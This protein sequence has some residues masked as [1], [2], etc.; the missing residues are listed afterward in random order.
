MSDESADETDP[1]AIVDGF[2]NEL[3]EIADRLFSADDLPESAEDV[4]TVLDEIEDVLQYVDI[5]DLVAAIDLSKL[6]EAIDVSSVPE[7]AQSGKA[8]KAVHLR[9]LLDVVDLTDLAKSLDLRAAWRE[10]RELDDAVD[11]LM[12][13]D[14]LGGDGMFDGDSDRLGSDESHDADVEVEASGAFDGVDGEDL[15]ALRMGVQQGVLEAVDEFRAGLLAAHEELAALHQANREANQR[16][17]ENQ[18]HSRNPTAVSTISR[19]GPLGSQTMKGSTVPQETK[20][21]KTPNRK[22]IYG[23]RFEEETDE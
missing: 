4:V 20:Y 2:L 17:K 7:A 16:R 15:D 23:A 6:P 18:S 9:K 12:D 19:G 1:E 22:R 8:R 5:E 21:S 10:G 13:G 14:V 3:A 11:D